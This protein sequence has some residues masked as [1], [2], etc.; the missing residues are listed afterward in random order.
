M[1]LGAQLYTVRHFT[2]SELDF[3]RSLEKI[4]AM[5]YKTVQ[6]SAIGSIPAKTV[7][8]IC[9]DNGL[10]IVLTHTDPDRILRDTDA[11]LEEHDILGCRHIG[12]GMMP[13]RYR[14]D[15]WVEG[16]VDDYKGPSQSIAAAGKL[17]MYHNHD[18][19]FAFMN[20][21]RIFDVL[22]DGFS[23]RELGFTLD[24]YWVHYAGADVC[25]WV[26]R[27]HGRLPCVHLK[28]REVVCNNGKWEAVMAPVLEGNMPFGAILG[29]FA[30]AGTEYLL[31]EQDICRESPFICLEKSYRNLAAL[32][33]Q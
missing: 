25:A 3:A 1:I 4:A 12:I 32:G 17:L 22:I 27:L 30:E 6:I 2:Q 7:R 8:K 18:I 29:A 19:E 5:G 16:F 11:V 28:D 14:Y 33:Y 13:E 21:K 9:D 24:T 15:A 26:K 23:A 31:V 10:G 20:G